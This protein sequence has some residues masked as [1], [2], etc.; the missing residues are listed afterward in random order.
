M[1]KPFGFV[2][3][4]LVVV[5]GCVPAQVSAQVSA[6]KVMD[7][8]A[9]GTNPDGS[10]YA[11]TVQVQQTGSAAV[12]VRWTIGGQSIEGIGVRSGNTVSAAYS[13][14]RRTTLVMYTMN[15][16]GSLRGTWAVH[17]TDGTGTENLTPR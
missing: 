11:G 8:A 4:G 7:Y 9:Q 16:D 13:D 1:R 12:R 6:Q 10:R 15:A 3:V 2:V 5:L 14:G 17:G